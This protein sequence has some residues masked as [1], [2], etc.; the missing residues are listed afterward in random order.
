M[1]G[2]GTTL[3]NRGRLLSLLAFWCCSVVTAQETNHKPP[4]VLV[5]VGGY[6]MHLLIAGAAKSDPTV[7]FFMV[8]VTLHCIGT[9]YCP[10]SVSLQGR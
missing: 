5:D 2:Q 10:R 6:R 8:L 3:A 7:V 1:K 9:W 4:G